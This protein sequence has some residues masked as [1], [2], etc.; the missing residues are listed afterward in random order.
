MR[1]GPVVRTGVP[2]GA[3]G[4]GGV[5]AGGGQAGAGSGG[6][7]ETGAAGPDG[8]EAGERG[9]DVA[10]GGGGRGGPGGPF[11]RLLHLGNVVVDVVLPVP[12]LPPRGGDVLASQAR[13]TAGGGFNVMSAAARQGLRVSYAGAHGT[14]PFADLARAALA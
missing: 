5:K 12:A 13:T 11:G 1:P 9:G 10:P 2:D 6:G 4:P 8:V 14:G 7:V 3:A